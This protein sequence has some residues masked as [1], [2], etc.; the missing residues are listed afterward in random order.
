MMKLGKQ[1]QTNSNLTLGYETKPEVRIISMVRLIQDFQKGL[2][3]SQT[4]YW[5]CIVRN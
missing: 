1:P 2:L 5:V 4:V 3:Q